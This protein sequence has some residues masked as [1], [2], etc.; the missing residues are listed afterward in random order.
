MRR[1]MKTNRYHTTG[2]CVVTVVESML[3]QHR[4]LQVS[5]SLLVRE[6]ENNYA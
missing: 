3:Y 4:V 1:C 5:I 6:C 2:T